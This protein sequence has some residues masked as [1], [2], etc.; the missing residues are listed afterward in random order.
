MTYPRMPDL[1]QHWA[2]KGVLFI[3]I[4]LFGCHSAHRI[5]HSLHDLGIHNGAM[6]T[7]ICYGGVLAITL[8]TAV[9]LLNLGF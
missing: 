9:S 5:F 7:L 1:A 2:G 3:V 4:V 6:A 8:V